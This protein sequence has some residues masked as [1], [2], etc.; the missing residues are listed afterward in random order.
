[1]VSPVTF[2]R[3]PV[4]AKIVTTV[5]HI[6][7]GRVELGIGAGWFEAEH[8]AYGFEFLTHARAARRARPAARGDRRA[9]GRTRRDIWPKPVQQPRPPIIV[10][11]TRE[12]AHRRAPPSRY[13]DEYNT[14]WPTVDEA[15]ERKRV[16]DDAARAAGR[17]PLRFSMMIGCVVGRDEAS[18]TSGSRSSSD[19]RQR[20]AADLRHRRRGRRA[21]ARVR[22]GRRRARDAAAP[23]PRGRRD[24]R[25]PGRGR[26]PSRLERVR[27]FL[28]RHAE[29]APGEPDEL[30]PLTA[31]GPRGRARARRAARRASSLDAVVSSPLLRA[32]ETAERS[33]APPASTPRPTSGSR[34][35]RPPTTC[36]TR[37]R[38]SGETGRRRRA[39]ARL[40]RDRARR[41]PAAS[42]HVR[43]GRRCARSSCERRRRHAACARATAST[44][45]CAASTSRSKPARCSACSARTAPARRRRSRSS[46]A[47]AT[48]DAGTVEVLGVDPQRSGT[49]VA[50]ARSA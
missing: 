33:R 10:G 35:A 15:R 16:L 42:E 44:K 37:S 21:A 32:R 29:A 13:A 14:V 22:A 46:R 7:G 4:L 26:G 23:R 38:G 3:V 12:A 11:G 34:P 48:R 1:M 25:R 50:R 18:S 30:R 20:R 39:P 49:R 27:L 31:G 19:H 28:V 36:A 43:A 8:E 9:S 6:S 5:D 45:R 17:E 47:T 2:R 40:Q 24:G 41:S